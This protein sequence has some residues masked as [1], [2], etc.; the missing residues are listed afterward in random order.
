LVVGGGVVEEREADEAFFE[1]NNNAL[2]ALED[3]NPHRHMKT[4][5]LLL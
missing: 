1:K 4:S 3:R 2:I 5:S